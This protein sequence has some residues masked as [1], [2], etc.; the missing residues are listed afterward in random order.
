MMSVPGLADK[1]VPPIAQ[2]A[3]RP[4]WRRITRGGGLGRSSAAS[5]TLYRV[6][7]PKR[8]ACGAM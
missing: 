7:P 5:V 2:A 6:Y 8:N 3:C 4:N 1:A